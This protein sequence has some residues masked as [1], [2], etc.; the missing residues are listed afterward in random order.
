M[1]IN[2]NTLYVI[3]L[4]QFLNRFRESIQKENGANLLVE[5]IKSVL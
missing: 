4:N 2:A 5:Q 3:S 1:R